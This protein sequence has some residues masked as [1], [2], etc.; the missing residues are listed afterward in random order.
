MVRELEPLLRVGQVVLELSA[1]LVLVIR[2]T[3]MRRRRQEVLFN[4]LNC[5]SGDRGES[6]LRQ[7]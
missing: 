1:Q 5:P 6:A 4:A 2:G 7:T 3:V